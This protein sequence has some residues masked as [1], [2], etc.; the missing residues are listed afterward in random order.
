MAAANVPLSTIMTLP[1]IR[2][3][4]AYCQVAEEHPE[5]REYQDHDNRQHKPQ[6][7]V[8]PGSLRDRS[9]RI[10]GSIA[11]MPVFP[12]SAFLLTS[13]PFLLLLIILPPTFLFAPM[14]LLFLPF[15]R[16]VG[17]GTCRVSRK[18]R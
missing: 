11:V 6:P 8:G 14:P 4:R 7:G 10:V 9:R 5:E 15:A 17:A 18:L 1:P 16:Q 3:T 12:L 13:A 2:A